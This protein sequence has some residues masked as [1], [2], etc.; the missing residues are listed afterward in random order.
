MIPEE[1]EVLQPASGGAVNPRRGGGGGHRVQ[2][3][4]LLHTTGSSFL[5]LQLHFQAPIGRRY[6]P[7]NQIKRLSDYRK[8]LV[9]PASEQTD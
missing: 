4:L 9:F 5:K 3:L 1:L 7:F 2:N 6:L 8:Q